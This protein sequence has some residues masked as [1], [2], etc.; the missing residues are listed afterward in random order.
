MVNIGIADQLSKINIMKLKAPD[1][2]TYAQKLKIAADHLANCIQWRINEFYDSYEPVVYERT[3]N[4]YNSLRVE[5][6][7]DIRVSGNTLSISLIFDEGANHES[8]FEEA[9]V[10]TAFLMNYGYQVHK[11]VW[12]KDIEYFGWRKG[13]HFIEKGI[14]DFNSTNKLGIRISIEKPDTYY[15]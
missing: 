9:S 3:Y 4:M 11:E 6:I 2:Q 12:F 13:F 7:A 8:L 14:E 15:V 10:N 5:D 1:G